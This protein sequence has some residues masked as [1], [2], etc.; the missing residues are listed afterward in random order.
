MMNGGC[1]AGCPTGSCQFEGF[2]CIPDVQQRF[3]SQ[4]YNEL[5]CRN[6]MI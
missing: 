5:R 2:M 4:S 3:V 1:K 6:D